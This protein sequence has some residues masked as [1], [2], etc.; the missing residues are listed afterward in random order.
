MQ[1]IYYKSP[2]GNFGDDLNA[3]L[4]RQLL[5]PEAFAA[6]DAVLLGIGS[7]FR[8]DFLSQS[9]TADKRVFVLGS[10][11]GTGPLPAAWPDPGWNILAVRGPL[12][13][14]VIG[15]PDSSVTDAAA[16]L[17]LTPEITPAAP[18]RRDVLFMPHYNSVPASRW[19]HIC[20]E[21]G[22]TFVD[23]RWSPEVVLRMLGSARLVITEA[24]HG[25]IVADTLR[26]PWIPL[27]CSPEIAAFKWVD[28][29]SSLDLPYEPVHIPPSSAWEAFR[30]RRLNASKGF[31]STGAGLSDADLIDEF[32]R[33]FGEAEAGIP[34][35]S[36]SRKAAGWMLSKASTVFD[37][38]FENRAAE[39]LQAAAAG[40]QYLS[41]DRVLANRVGRLEQAVT[42]LRRALGVS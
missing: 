36:R 38:L 41:G 25:A 28:W 1:V 7:I 32:Q 34:E 14:R 16:L 33:T 21:L 40:P 42:D 11:A 27:V 22:F 35:P 9:A 8:E 31:P 20:A 19:P 12:T 29:A 39:A 6:D 17:A 37:R 30:H 13:A 26:I 18:D 2:S 3:V 24:M 4:W 10:G 23:M 5:P 15:R